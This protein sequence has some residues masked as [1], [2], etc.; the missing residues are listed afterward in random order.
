M[1]TALLK[2]K[3]ALRGDS[4]TSLAQKMGIAIVTLSLK[5]TGQ[6]NF[7]QGEIDFIR[8][9]YNL[10]PEEVCEIFFEAGDGK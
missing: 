4:Q 7:T 8:K 10:T 2:S 1:N 6:R 9:E 3:M 5:M